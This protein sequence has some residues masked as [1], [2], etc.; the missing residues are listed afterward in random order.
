MN[1]AP[2]VARLSGISGGSSGAPAPLTPRRLPPPPPPAPVPHAART[3][4]ACP[5]R[6][7]AAALGGAGAGRTLRRPAGQRPPSHVTKAM[8]LDKRDPTTL[9]VVH[10]RVR[11]RTHRP[12]AQGGV[13]PATPHGWH[14]APRALQPAWACPRGIKLRRSPQNHPRCP[15]PSSTKRRAGGT[16]E[17]PAGRV[18]QDVV[19]PPKSCGSLS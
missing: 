7:E 15:T 4:G 18:R 2:S 8:A 16:L 13:H 14:G 9:P 19:M 12:P 11:A 5:G 17:T 6:G 1:P 3:A 10:R